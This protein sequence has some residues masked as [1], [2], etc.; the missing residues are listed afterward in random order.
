M[1]NTCLLIVLLCTQQIVNGAAAQ[2]PEIISYVPSAQDLAQAR[3]DLKNLISKWEKHSQTTDEEPSRK[4]WWLWHI[5]STYISLTRKYPQL[6]EH[7]AIQH[8]ID[9]SPGIGVGDLSLYVEPLASQEEIDQYNKL[10]RTR[11]FLNTSPAPL[12]P[13]KKPK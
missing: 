11:D 10:T 1:K 7:E 13:S 5:A 4:N 8:F 12:E 3:N 9:N 6:P 2:E